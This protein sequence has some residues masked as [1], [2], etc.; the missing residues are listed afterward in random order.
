[1]ESVTQ[2]NF[3]V[4]KK[5]WAAVLEGWELHNIKKNNRCLQTV[6]SKR[7]LSKYCE[8]GLQMLPLKTS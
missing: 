8:T 4:L 6:S 2:K 1:M 3:A 7:N 5:V